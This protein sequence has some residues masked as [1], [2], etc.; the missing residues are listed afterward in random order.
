MKWAYQ[1]RMVKTLKLPMASIGRSYCD[2]APNNWWEIDLLM[3]ESSSMNQVVCIRDT[4][5]SHS[6]GAVCLVTCT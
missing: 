2:K 3:E 5:H 6:V 4:Q 1:I